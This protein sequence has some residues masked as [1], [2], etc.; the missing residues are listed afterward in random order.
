MFNH[1]CLYQ[2]VFIGG[3]ERAIILGK[4]NKSLFEGSASVGIHGPKSL[5]TV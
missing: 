3:P 5:F 4:P 2:G 1:G